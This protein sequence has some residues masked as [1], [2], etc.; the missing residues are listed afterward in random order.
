[1]PN[2]TIGM[3]EPLL[4]RL[5]YCRCSNILRARLPC[6]CLQ[7]AQFSTLLTA[8]GGISGYDIR[9]LL[10]FWLL[11][12]SPLEGCCFSSRVN[13]WQECLAYFSKSYNDFSLHQTLLMK[14]AHMYQTRNRTMEEVGSIYKIVKFHLS[15]PRIVFICAMCGHFTSCCINLH[16]ARRNHRY[17][18]VKCLHNQCILPLK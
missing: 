2:G 14:V 16:L 13:S 7:L 15:Q 1:M 5:P 4:N 18:C 12:W 6:T 10:M 11:Q 3:R 17:W 8:E 9:V